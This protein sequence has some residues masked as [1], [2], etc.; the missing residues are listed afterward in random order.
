MKPYI[1]GIPRC[2]FTLMHLHEGWYVSHTPHLYYARLRNVL[3]QL[4]TSPLVAI[5][6]D[7]QSF[8]FSCCLPKF[9]SVFI[10]HLTTN[11]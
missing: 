5:V 10:L 9:T 11:P 2:T 1:K 4:T 3:V 6:R 8:D 7:K